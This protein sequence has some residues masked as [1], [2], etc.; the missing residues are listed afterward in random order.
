MNSR[1]RMLGGSPAFAAV[2]HQLERGAAAEIPILLLGESGTG[3]ELAAR[4]VHAQSPRSQGPFVAV[5]LAALPTSLVEDELF[6]HAAGAFTGATSA[7]SGRFR[8][9][10]G[11][12]LF[13]DEIGD[14]PAG[15]QVKLLR[16]LQEKV[17][18][19]LGSEDEEP[20]DVRVVA[21]TNRDLRSLASAGTFRPDLLFRLSVLPVVLPPL[22]ERVEDIGSLARHFAR[23]EH[24][25]LPVRDVGDDA[26]ELLQRFPW[27]G[28]VRELENAVMRAR[29][30]ASGPALEAPDFEFLLKKP[31]TAAADVAV[32][33]LRRGVTLEAMERAMLDEALRIAHGNE[34]EAAR[35]LGM[36]RRAVEYRRSKPS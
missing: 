20:I 5:N 31:A 36:S 28:N 16:A 35:R 27:P 13:L 10:N 2:L 23:M 7:R 8:R 26:V 9:A 4:F 1:P 14:V 24:D 25:R 29:A 33:A 32:E 17:I 6:G 18:E 12:T 22:R 34:A 11:G 15:V 30:L 19:P 3:K 21:A